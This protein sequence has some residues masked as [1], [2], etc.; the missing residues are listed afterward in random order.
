MPWSRF[1]VSPT[2]VR[3]SP[4]PEVCAMPR[5]YLELGSCPPDETPAQLGSPNYLELS[6]SECREYI[7]AIRRHMGPEPAGA[8]LVAKSFPHD[9]GTYREVVCYYE[10]EKSAA[11]AFDCERDGPQR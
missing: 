11:Y 1:R 3:R 8:R 5:E 4:L 10:D 7:G 9:F 2:R 6:L